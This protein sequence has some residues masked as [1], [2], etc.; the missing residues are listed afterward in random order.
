[1][2]IFIRSTNI[3][4]V[5]IIAVGCASFKKSNPTIIACDNLKGTYE[6]I[7][8]TQSKIDSIRK[9]GNE[10][11]FIHSKE[12]QTLENE[13]RSLLLEKD[14]LTEKCKS[15]IENQDRKESKRGLIESPYSNK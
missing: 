7:E 8:F 13:K 10:N 2:K 14:A 5:V 12:I 4:A 1:M 11:N 9:L 3:A 15:V 6:K